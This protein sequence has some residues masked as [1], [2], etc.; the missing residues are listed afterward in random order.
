MYHTIVEDLE[1]GST[2]RFFMVAEAEGGFG[3]IS[4]TLYD[5]IPESG[6]S[7]PP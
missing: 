5:T 2:Y 4:E 3:P 1:P 6:K 7:R